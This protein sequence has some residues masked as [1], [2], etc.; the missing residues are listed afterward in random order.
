MKGRGVGE[1]RTREC[2]FVRA[3][4]HSDGDGDGD[5]RD[6][7]MPNITLMIQSGERVMWRRVSGRKEG[8]GSGL[9]CLD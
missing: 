4:G 8:K 5:G 1:G 9:L 2:L 7:V 3:Q 6:I